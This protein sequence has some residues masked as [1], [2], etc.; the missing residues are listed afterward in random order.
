M[1]KRKVSREQ[2]KFKN[3]IYLPNELLHLI[4]TFLDLKSLLSL[5]NTSREIY[6]IIQDSPEINWSCFI[7]ELLIK[8]DSDVILYSRFIENYYTLNNL[9]KMKPNSFDCKDV[10]FAIYLKKYTFRL[11]IDHMGGGYC[12]NH[13]FIIFPKIAIKRHKLITSKSAREKLNSSHDEYDF[14]IESL[15]GYECFDEFRK[16]MKKSLEKMSDDFN[17]EKTLKSIRKMKKVKKMFKIQGISKIYYQKVH[18]YWDTSEYNKGEM[19]FYGVTN[20]NNLIGFNWS[21]YHN[22]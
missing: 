8:K 18:Y 22:V 2:K 1:V 3:S 12:F 9:D 15:K 6:K 4:S 21:V 11:P 10:L 14:T 20:N 16:E 5:Q 17:R 19:L 7:R 13:P